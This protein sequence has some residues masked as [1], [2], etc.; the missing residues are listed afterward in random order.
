[1]TKNISVA[2]PT[3]KN[4]NTKSFTDLQISRQTNSSGILS[5]QNLSGGASGNR[6]QNQ[7]ENH[8]EVID[9]IIRRNV[10]HQDDSSDSGTYLSFTEEVRLRNGYPKLISH[11]PSIDLDLKILKRSRFF[12]VNHPKFQNDSILDNHIRT[13]PRSMRSTMKLNELETRN[14]DSQNRNEVVTNHRSRDS[15]LHH[16]AHHADNYQFNESTRSVQFRVEYFTF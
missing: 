11:P 13:L 10:I 1:M 12:W 15:R 2:L 8:Y 9:D 4:T 5:D 7:T 16:P 6:L 14:R 3:I